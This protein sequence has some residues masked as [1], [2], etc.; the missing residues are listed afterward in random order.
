MVL[1]G[2]SVEGATRYLNTVEHRDLT[3]EGERVPRT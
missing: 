1:F 2:P 3:A